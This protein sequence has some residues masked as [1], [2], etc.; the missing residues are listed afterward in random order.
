MKY[1]GKSFRVRITQSYVP[2][3]APYTFTLAA[4]LGMC[5]GALGG[6]G[7]EGINRVMENS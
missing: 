1:S 7:L 5:R 6:A 3:M 4:G 2:E